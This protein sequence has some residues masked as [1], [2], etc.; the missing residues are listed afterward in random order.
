M[1]IIRTVEEDVAT[2]LVAEIYAD[3]RA[4][5][6]YVPPHTKAM[7]MNPE[8]MLAWDALASAVAG[9]MDKR[10]Y[11]LVTLAA[12]EAI[13]SQACLLA[14]SLKSLRYMP[15]E[16]V[17]AV[18]RDYRDAGLTDAEVAMM[19]YAA[20]LSGDSASMTDADSQ[21]LRDH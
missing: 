7:A 12:A 13:G 19:E 3:D 4:H 18:A 1:S 6:G 5:M 20:K 10:R 9:P 14:H 8:A 15:E 2:G 21:A 11:E 16:T 17:L